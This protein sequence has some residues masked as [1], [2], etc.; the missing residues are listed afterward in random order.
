[1]TSHQEQ[2]YLKVLQVERIC[3]FELSWGEGQIISVKTQYPI[4]L[5]NLYQHWCRAYINF[6]NQYMMRGKVIDG[7][8]SYVQNED[9]H[10]QLVRAEAQLIYK[11]HTWLRSAELY[12]IR[13]IIAESLGINHTVQIFLSCESTSLARLPWEIWEISGKF[14]RKKA[15]QIIRTSLNIKGK[16]SAQKQHNR[17]RTRILGILGDDTG[18]NLFREKETILNS[19]H[20][21]AEVRFIER[22][23]GQEASQILQDIKSVLLDENGWDI[24][25]FLGHAHENSMTGG[26]IEI[27]PNMSISMKDISSEI[28]VAKDRGLKVAIF[29][30]CT[31]LN[32]GEY[33]INLGLS[34]V[35]VMREAIHNDVAETFTE[36][37]CQGLA[38]HLDVYESVAVAREFFYIEKSLTYPSAYLLPSIF[39]HPKA[40]LFRIPPNHNFMQRNRHLAIPKLTESIAVV[41]S[42]GLS[43]LF[44]IQ[45]FLLDTRVF[46]Q[47]VYRSATAQTSSKKI[48]PVALVEIDTESIIK[49]QLPN[50]Q[51]SPINRSY[52]AS[53]IERVRKSNASIIG[54]NFI[55]EQENTP[56]G[57]KDL[58]TAVNN[59]V[60]ENK[61]VIFGTILSQNGEKE[62]SLDNAGIYNRKST[63]AG[64]TDST[65]S[66]VEFP[67][68]LDCRQTCPISYLMALTKLATQEITEL[69]LPNA[70][71][72]DLR[73]QLLNVI[74][75]N[76]PSEGNLAAL[77]QWRPL[78][79][80]QPIVD[81]SIPPDQVY[82]KI[83]ARQLLEAENIDLSKQVVIIAGGYDER[84]GM[85][86]GLDRLPSPSATRYWTE[87]TWQTGGQSL[88]Y[89]THH[90]L[91]HHFITP[92]PDIWMIGIA[93]IV[94]KI[95]VIVLSKKSLS[96]SRLQQISAGAVGTV[97]IYGI[98]GLQIYISAGLLL[99]WFFPSSVFLAY[100]LPAVNKKSPKS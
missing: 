83:S 61:W 98:A 99:P 48:P 84:L 64:Y 15:V 80:I 36:H 43:S 57:D 50:S 23:T 67:S 27:A 29:N 45:D 40:E 92:I 53:L 12:A 97:A 26:E 34:Q 6:Y 5:E 95:T 21:I 79:G 2:F 20:R 66:Y 9:W 11:F 28:S 72:T 88:A 87:Q 30:A 63:M 60:N 38:S 51:L 35:V 96:Q 70:S 7:G 90:Y 22:Q 100:V 10:G 56:S 31:G 14:A 8:I 62:L 86:P 32:I 16:V 71:N 44:P 54:L 58:R 1:M 82:K 33:L 85:I 94:G 55:I 93:V 78:F 17:K 42:L 77:K 19:L 52:L 24:L 81:F 4:E 25:F 47:A 68:N 59:A 3:L 18:L 74:N 76:L 41:A 13:E 73:T 89:T 69:P 37:F 65:S 39:Y 49:A 75:K 46:T 91:T